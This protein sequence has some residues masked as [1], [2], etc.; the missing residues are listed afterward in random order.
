MTADAAKSVRE[1]AELLGITQHAVLALIRNG[2]IVAVNVSVK[3]TG[4]PR[5]KILPDALEGF[6][7]RRASK[8]LPQRRRRRKRRAP[9]K[10]YF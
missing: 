7:L 8:G 4:R 9:L 2:D 5:W 6:L 3:A 10:E 1:V